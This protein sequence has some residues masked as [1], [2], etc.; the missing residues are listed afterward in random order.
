MGNLTLYELTAEQAAIEE[1]LIDNGG[2]LTPEIEAALE[3][4]NEALSVKADGYCRIL[5]KFEGAEAAIDG[6]IKRLQ[7]LKKTAQN[8]QKNLRSHILGA[9]LEHGIEKIECPL[10]KFSTRSSSAVEVADDFLDQFEQARREF[11]TTLPSFVSVD[12]KLSKTALRDAILAGQ[13]VLGAEIVNNKSL[14]IR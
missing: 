1:A 2:E 6:E 14:Q 5:H 12:L 8:A 3:A 7:G 11:A 4:N 13:P 9:M 10:G